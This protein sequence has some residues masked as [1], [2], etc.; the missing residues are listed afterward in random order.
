M[1]EKRGVCVDVGLIR[2]QPKQH[3]IV[4]SLSNPFGI[5]G[6]FEW[7]GEEYTVLS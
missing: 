5:C 1:G 4:Q 3:E 2:S 7:D 6:E